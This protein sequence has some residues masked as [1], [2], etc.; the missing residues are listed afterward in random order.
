MTETPQTGPQYSDLARIAM[1]RATSAR[2]AVEIVASLI[3]EYGFST[4]GGNSHFFADAQEGW[5]MKQMAG[6]QG[7]WVA[8]RVGCDDVRLSYP[9]YILEIPDNYQEHPDYMGSDNLISFAVEQG[10]YD[11]DAGEPFNVN[12]VYGNGQGRQQPL[13]RL[14]GPTIADFEERVREMAPVTLEGMQ[15]LVRTPALSGDSTG[16]DQVA[17]LRP[18]FPRDLGVLWV[19]PTSSVTTPFVPYYI[20]SNEVPPEFGWHRYMH[21]DAATVFLT[22]D[23]QHQEASEFATRTFKRLLY[24]TCAR[25][26]EF[27]HDV[28]ATLAGFEAQTADAMV[29]LEPS[30]QHLLD[31]GEEDLARRLLTDFSVTPARESLQLGNALVDGLEA[32]TRYQYGFESPEGDAWGRL[33]YTMIMCIPPD[34]PGLFD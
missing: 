3:D 25:P 32:R 6:S 14:D 2:E 12:A 22:E 11:P 31:A 26:E 4:Y 28:Q 23:Y 18:D 21:K 29:G 34:G 33:D 9:G 10:W 17:H 20:G 15:A 7:L 19:A 24:Y 13:F 27:L 8:E 30:V 5:V 1:D 16:C